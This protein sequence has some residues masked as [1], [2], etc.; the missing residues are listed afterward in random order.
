MNYNTLT[1]ESPLLPTL[2]KHIAQPP[3][4]LFYIGDTLGEL[5]K[6]PR[7]A[8]VGSRAISPYGRQ[9]TARLA[10]ELAELGIVII[11]GLAMGVDA[12]A[13][14]AALEAGGQCIAVLPSPLDNIVPVGNRQL[15]AD[16]VSQGGVLLTEYEPGSM[17]FKNNFVERNRL[18][19]GLADAVLI[20][21]ASDPSGT[22]HTAD[23]ANEQGRL[24]MAVPGNV[25]SK[26]SAGANKLIRQ[27]ARFVRNT[28][29][30]IDELNLDLQLLLAI[31]PHGRNP[32]EQAI[33]RLVQDGISAS[34]Q[35]LAQSRLSIA[36][37]SR[38][39]TTLEL[40]GK[41]RQLG[42]DHWALP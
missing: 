7:V 21:E 4:K 3:N 14:R 13:H 42:G 31:T 10:R 9:V 2:F 29:D 40:S 24:V 25:T 39:I 30:I 8:I 20:T 28:Q 32:E 19:S 5:S 34:N 41:I 16:I 18:M 22:L 33:L 36:V 6:R 1:L 27:G 11:S 37:F 12:C 17:T 38:T 26:Q 15:A 23:F 35:L